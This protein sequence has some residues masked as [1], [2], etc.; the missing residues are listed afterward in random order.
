MLTQAISVRRATILAIAAVA[1]SLPVMSV[2]QAAQRTVKHPVSAPQAYLFGQPV[3]YPCRYVG[4]VSGRCYT[5]RSD[6][7]W[8]AG[9]PGYTGTNGG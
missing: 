3:S 9:I 8:P 6:A 4:A 7:T 2:A 1:L 5:F